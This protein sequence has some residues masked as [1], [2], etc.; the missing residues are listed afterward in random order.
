MIIVALTQLSVLVLWLLKPEANPIETLGKWSLYGQWLVLATAALLCVF[1]SKIAQ[2]SYS[3]GLLSVIAIGLCVLFSIELVAISWANGFSE[4]GFDLERLTR[5][6]LADMLI[7]LVI[8]RFF[9]FLAVMENRNMAES[10]SRIEAL[11]SRIQPHFLFNSLNTISELT[12]TQPDQAEKAINSLSMLF[13]AS[14]ENNRKTHSL[15]N[16]LSLSYRYIEL[17]RWRVAERL[18]IN[19]NVDIENP[20]EW[21]IPKLIVQPLIEN[22]IVHGVQPDGSI[23]IDV[24]LRETEKYI[25]LKIENKL[26]FETAHVKGHGIAI[27]NIQERLFVLFDDQQTFRTKQEG[28]IYSVIMRFPK[29]KYV[30]EAIT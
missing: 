7:L 2:L 17:E 27:E 13:R 24:D 25:S 18:T 12:A 4:W 23:S 29:L 8:L 19:W 14:L 5:F 3:L 30:A 28:E 10:Q 22:A 21:S 16:E 9:K 26:G 20:A 15:A 6:A 11:Q 1:R